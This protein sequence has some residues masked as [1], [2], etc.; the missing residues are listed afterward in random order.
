MT[1]SLR[2]ARAIAAAILVTCA[3]SAAAQTPISAEFLRLDPPRP[4]AAPGRVEVIK[5]FYY[6]CPVCYETQPTLTRWLAAAPDYI[7]LRRVP[8]LSSE[9]WEPYAKLFY[10]LESLGEIGRLHW[11]IYDSI[12]FWDVRPGEETSMADWVASKGV[13]R[14]KF[15]DAYES[16]EVATRV[17]LARELLKAYGVRGVP[18]FII[19]GRFLTSAKLAGGTKQVIEVVDRLVKLARQEQPQ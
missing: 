2:S 6:G 11:P 8:A 1:K 3:F 15:L 19:D 18:T 16:Q 14:R 4:T 13:E 12:H 17:A 10:A 9:R 5:F 7:T